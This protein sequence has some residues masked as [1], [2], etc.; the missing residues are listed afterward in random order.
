MP[1][2]RASPASRRTLE[3]VRG[4]AGRST[5]RRPAR[6][7]RPVRRRTS[8]RARERC[9]A[10]WP[11]AVRRATISGSSKTSISAGTTMAL[12]RPSSRA[13]FASPARLGTARLRRLA[14]AASVRC[15]M[16]PVCAARSC[17]LVPDQ[18][19]QGAVEADMRQRQRHAF[20]GA[21]EPRRP[22]AQEAER[23]MRLRMLPVIRSSETSKTAPDS[24]ADRRETWRSR[25]RRRRSRR[26]SLS[27]SSG[28]PMITGSC[29]RPRLTDAFAGRPDR[30]ERQTRH[31]GAGEIGRA[32]RRG[33]PAAAG[34]RCS[35]SWLAVMQ[36]VG[37]GRGEQDAV[38]RAS[39]TGR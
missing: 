34:S 3:Q 16:P 1:A 39:R 13:V 21:L 22:E 12:R 25:S 20:G 35:R 24:P 4:S 15:E 33:R 27:P 26:R 9:A 37:L 5:G 14:G 23:R 30:G 19:L 36:M 31:L 8:C 7:E 38:D 29:S 2:A 6:P 10:R 18:E 17:E 32:R 28:M 11:A